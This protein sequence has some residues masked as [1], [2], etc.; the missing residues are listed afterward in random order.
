MV[1]KILIAGAFLGGGIFLIKKLL[2]LL[3]SDSATSLQI[4]NEVFDVKKWSGG[5]KNTNYVPLEGGSVWERPDFDP[6]DSMEGMAN[7]SGS[8]LK[9]KS[10]KEFLY[11]NQI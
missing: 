8:A 11:L 1:K 3:Q 6:R 7:F 5:S 10:K 4:E 2:P 9:P